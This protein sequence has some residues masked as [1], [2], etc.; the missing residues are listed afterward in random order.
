MK[1][2]GSAATYYVRID[3]MIMTI[4]R[5]FS[6]SGAAKRWT[7]TD[8]VYFDITI[9]GLKAG[10]IVIGLFGTIVPKT[11]NNFKSLA[12]GFIDANKKMY[13]YKGSK[14]HRVIKDFMIQ[15]GD[16]TRGDG[17]GGKSIYGDKFDDEN[18]K[19]DHHGEGLLSMANAGQDTNGSQ[20]FITT[21]ATPWLDGKH[22]VFGKVIK[23][24]SVVRTIENTPT[25]RAKPIEDV[26]IVDCGVLAIKNG[27]FN[28][29]IQNSTSA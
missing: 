7:V 4:I 8:E 16:V 2:S 25:Y 11:F 9:G 28:V 21:V 13:S 14:F 3:V 27:G 26:V 6:I 17:F 24:M 19:I 5:Y 22:V 29:K 23:G 20:F 10:R 12:T 18:F 15:G 1:W